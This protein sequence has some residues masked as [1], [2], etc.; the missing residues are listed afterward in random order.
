MLWLRLCTKD[1]L[2][3]N[4]P[5]SIG[6]EVAV[7]LLVQ[8]PFSLLYILATCACFVAFFCGVQLEPSIG[9]IC[10]FAATAVV[11]AFLWNFKACTTAM[12]CCKNS[13]NFDIGEIVSSERD[14]TNAETQELELVFEL[15]GLSS[16]VLQ[17]H[18]HTCSTMSVS[19]M[20]FVVGP[21]GACGSS[22]L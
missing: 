20:C 7:R 8:Q 13:N 4:K 22:C 12:G 19:I 3:R 17:V 5:R 2:A 21:R 16:K 1:F 11:T 18:A 15:T 10:A 14:E 9:Q 6:E